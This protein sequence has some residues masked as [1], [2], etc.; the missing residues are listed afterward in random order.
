M[1]KRNRKPRKKNRFASRVLVVLVGLILGLGLYRW[2]ASALAG[3]AL[4]MPFGTG[5][6]VVLSGSMSPTL[7]VND[8]VIVR[9]QD[10]YDVG[11]I[12]VYQS[13]S[14]LIVHRIIAREGPQ[15]TTQGDANNTPDAPVD[16]RDVKGA[17]TAHVPKLGAVV[18][19]LKRPMVGIALLILACVLMDHSF[20]IQ[21]RAEEEDLDAIKEEIRRLKS[22]LDP[23]RKDS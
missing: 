22:E 6:A 4:P 3:N 7:E 2:N 14:S 19:V 10:R 12:V 23:D 15:L 21:K 17:V 8:L 20:R 13:G 16:V 11:D 1:A 5:A 18:Q 9:E